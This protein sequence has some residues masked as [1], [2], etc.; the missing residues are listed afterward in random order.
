MDQSQLERA[1]VSTRA[2]LAS[3]SDGDLDRAT[4]CQSWSVRQLVNHMIAAPR[5]SAHVLRTGERMA[6]EE[7]YTAGDFKAAYDHSAAVALAAFAEEGALHKTVPLPFGEVPGAFLLIMVTGDQ[8]TH[9][10]DL[11]TATGQSTDLDP[12]LAEVLL[13]EAQVPD[14][15]RGDDGAAPFGP[16]RHAPEGASA[17]DRLAAYL[18]RS[19]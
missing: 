7:E 13:V 10:W 18:G 4:P 5:F 12:G 19:V 11:A 17:A 6:D 3:V 1:F 2:V 8:F 9:G 14:Q 16:V 15:L